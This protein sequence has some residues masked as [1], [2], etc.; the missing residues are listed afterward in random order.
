MKSFFINILIF[1]FFC[2]K[3]HAQAY[4][5]TLG[6]R[7]LGDFGFTIQQ[8]V[9]KTI[10]IE[11]ILESDTKDYTALSILGEFHQPILIK[12]LNF[13]TGIGAHKGWETLAEDPWGISAI[14]GIEVTLRHLSF[15]WDYKPSFHLAGGSQQFI[16]NTAISMRFIVIKQKRPRL[17]KKRR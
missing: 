11:G 3:I 9:Y 2:S 8:K 17:F 12:R 1:L 16:N 13:Y 6:V 15:S 5:T 14:A 10:T 4:T 7:A